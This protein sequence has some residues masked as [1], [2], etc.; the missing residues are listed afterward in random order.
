[1]T[2]SPGRFRQVLIRVLLV[3][4]ISLAALWWLQTRYHR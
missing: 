3:Q 2:E 1:M 4:L